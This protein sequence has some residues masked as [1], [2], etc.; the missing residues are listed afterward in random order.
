M[1]DELAAYVTSGSRDWSKYYSTNGALFVRTENINKNRLGSLTEIAR[2]ALPDSVEGKR[3]R[4]KRNDLLITI[5]GANVGKCAHVDLDIPEAYVSQSV[6]LVR[7]VDEAIAKFVQRQ[8]IS[9]SLSGDKT[10]L[11]ES[12]YG[13][14]RPV[15]N[16][17]NVRE[18]PIAL[19]PLPE[20]KRIADKLDTLLARIDACRDRLDRLPNIIKLFR[21]SVLT[22]AMS[23]KLTEEWRE[24]M[25]ITFEDTWRTKKLKDISSDVSYG[26]TASSI[27]MPN[28]PRMLR[29]TD[30]QNNQ[31]DW[32]SV[33]YCEIED[34][35]KN[36]YI[37]KD[38]DLVF[39]RTGATVGKSF[40]I[41]GDIPEAVFASYLI[42]VRCDE[43][44]SIEYL[45]LFFQSN[46]YW[47][48]IMEFSAGVAQPSVNGSKLKELII[49]LPNVQEQHEIV[50]RVDSL[51][52]L[53]DRLETRAK[54]ARAR[55]D[56]LTPSTL[57][58]AFRGELVP[59]DPNDEPASVLLE[60]IRAEKEL[61]PRTRN[62]G[63]ST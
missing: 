39:A 58:K 22:A 56:T 43:S 45:S 5:T 7:L 50:R 55:V 10:L 44:N 11:Q 29:I 59:Q 19:P 53:A 18:I 37:L 62:K 40:L 54:T 17:S 42:R 41:W 63:R 20:Q 52:D 13:I 3:T 34:S 25:G 6:A 57:A 48:Q 1:L 2:V 47:S 36:Q 60:R 16:L 30:I 14:G 49:P 12:A 27:P 15:L 38:G 4:I 46:E 23:G 33:P 8:L 51:F 61:T 9:P 32:S 24:H 21:R 35:K 31:V 26:F 28:G